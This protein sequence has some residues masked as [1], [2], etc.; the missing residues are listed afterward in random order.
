MLSRLSAAV[1]VGARAVTSETVQVS[2]NAT[3]PRPGAEARPAAGICA[4]GIGSRRAPGSTTARSTA[5]RGA[6]RCPSRCRSRRNCSAGCA[7]I[8]RGDQKREASHEQTARRGRARIPARS[9]AGDLPDVRRAAKFGHDGAARPDRGP[10]R[11]LPRRCAG[12]RARRVAARR[13]AWSRNRGFCF[14]A[15]RAAAAD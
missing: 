13:P 1:G 9:A 6:R 5:G 15:Q 11:L 8:S 12:R 7:R 4:S 3:D 10:R 2:T 14:L